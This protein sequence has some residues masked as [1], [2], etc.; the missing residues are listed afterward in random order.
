MCD[1]GMVLDMLKQNSITRTHLQTAPDQMLT[2][3]RDVLGEVKTTTTDSLITLEWN[4]SSHK[5]IQ[6]N[7]KTPHSQLISIVTLLNYPL[8]R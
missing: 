2:L 7:S 6:E 3:W 8:W 1:P 4:V 5:I